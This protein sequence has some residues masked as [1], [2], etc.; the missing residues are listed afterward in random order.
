MVESLTDVDRTG[1]DN[2]GCGAC[3]LCAAAS[4]CQRAVQSARWT[5]RTSPRTLTVDARRVD[6][7]AVQG[8][9]PS[10]D[11]VVTSGVACA[12]RQTNVETNVESRVLSYSLSR[13]GRAAGGGR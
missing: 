9:D 13:L 8:A 6:S 3:C 10:P 12:A 2:G 11:S 1:C 4:R 7:R 5:L